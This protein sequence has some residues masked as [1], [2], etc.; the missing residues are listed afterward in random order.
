MA[1]TDI[2]AT[3]DDTTTKLCNYVVKAIKPMSAMSANAHLWHGLQTR[4]SV[5]RERD[6][7]GISTMNRLDGTGPRYYLS[8]TESLHIYLH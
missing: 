5:E 1:T 3:N 4:S 2:T 6:A 8:D 7:I